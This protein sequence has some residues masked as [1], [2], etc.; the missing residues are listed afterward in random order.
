[1]SVFSKMFS[2]CFIVIFCY[3]L[4][5][6]SYSLIILSNPKPSPKDVF[7]TSNST[8]LQ[9]LAIGKAKERHPDD[10]KVFPDKFKDVNVLDYLKM[11]KKRKKKDKEK[12]YLL[13]FFFLELSQK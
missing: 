7:E 5:S 4:P 10:N 11:K 1:M 13:A 6:S 9:F 2:K 3:S 12:N 8:K